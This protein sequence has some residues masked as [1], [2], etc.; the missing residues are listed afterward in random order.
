MTSSK[1]DID[2]IQQLLDDVIGEDLH[3]KPLLSADASIEQNPMVQSIQD[4]ARG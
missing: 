1:R 4:K 2:Y 3:L